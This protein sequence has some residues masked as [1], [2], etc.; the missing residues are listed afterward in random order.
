M[1]I[2]RY[3]LPV[4][5]ALFAATGSASAASGAKAPS[6]D[7]AKPTD[8]TAGKWG[9]HLLPKALQKNPQLDMTVI[10]EMTP[11]G[12]KRPLV[13]PEAPAYY[14]LQ[15][16]KLM[17][18]GEGSVGRKPVPADA[19]QTM[20]QSAL[21]K[22]GFF[23]AAPPD[24]APTLFVVCQWGLHAGISVDQDTDFEIGEIL[25]E[26]KAKGGQMLRHE[27]SD[28]I[29]HD[30][31]MRLSLLRTNVL[32]QK[33]LLER[34]ALV[35]GEQFAREFKRVLELTT[36]RTRRFQ[37]QRI[38]LTNP[39][40]SALHGFILNDPKA[41]YLF[42]QAA[43]DVYF[44]VATAYDYDAFQRGER[45]GLWRTKMT[46]STTGVSMAESIPVLVRGAAPFLGRPMSEA[47]ML[48]APVHRGA[49]VDI[50]PVEVVPEPAPAP[51]PER[52]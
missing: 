45:H 2:T 28:G 9:F 43:N 10:T 32:E 39:E 12:A 40:E 42:D 5:L 3:L 26:A 16:T 49:Q 38:Y 8:T 31:E 21:A 33:T 47:A 13:T 30:P 18:V 44:V 14:F 46:V 48:N 1:L 17:S 29:A 23:A 25:D 51:A 15:P 19:L 7:E 37:D 22:N 36:D 52:K 20:L 34:A 35:G 4:P 24:H 11:E 50:G 6:V 27:V 41:R